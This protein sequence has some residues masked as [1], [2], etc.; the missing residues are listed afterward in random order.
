[1]PCHNRPATMAKGLWLKLFWGKVFSKLMATDACRL[2]SKRKCSKGRSCSSCWLGWGRSKDWLRSNWTF[3]VSRFSGLS[4]QRGQKVA[5]RQ[6]LV[7]LTCLLCDTR[8][9][10]GGME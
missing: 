4:G 9:A 8:L 2:F 10:A 5:T 6:Y 7:L 1:M 3:S